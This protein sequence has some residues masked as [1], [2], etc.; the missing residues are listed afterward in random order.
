MPNEPIALSEVLPLIE[1]MGLKIEYMSGPYE[2]AAA[3]RHAAVFMHEF[4][5]RPAH[6]PIV[7]FARR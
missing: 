5:G 6:A 4:V 2:I 3:G 7:D 1:N